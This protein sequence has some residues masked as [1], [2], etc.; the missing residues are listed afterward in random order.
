MERIIL[1]LILC[2]GTMIMTPG[3]EQQAGKLLSEAIYQEEVNGELDE[4]IK[5]YQSIV[6]Q[7]PDDRKVSA[8]ALLHL[9]ICYEKIGMPQAF[10]TYMDIIDKYAEQLDE[11]AL[12]QKR[13]NNLEAYADAIDEKAV[14]HMNKG[15]EL[16]KLW[17]YESAIIEYEEVI[18]LRPNTL[19]AQNAQYNIGQS[20]FKAGR[21]EDALKTFK[22]LIEDYPDSKIVPVT[23]LMVSQ[24]QYTMQNTENPETAKS[25][26]G[27]ATIVDPETDITFRK[28][29]TLTGESDIITYTTDLN[30]SPNGK[31]LLFG[32]MVVPMDGAAPFELI[33]FTST[34]IHVT[35]GTWSPDGNNAA[36]YS[37]DALCVVPV[38]SETGHTTGPVK[39]IYK[40]EL[41]YQRN[42][43]WSPDGKKITYQDSEADLWI[44]GSDGTNLIQITK[45]D[46]REV[47]PAWSPDGKT[48]AY[49]TRGKTLGLYHIGDNKFYELTETGFRWFPDWSPDGKWIV[50]DE[51]GK[52]H[53]YNPDNNSEFDFSPPEETG[54]F[55]SWSRDGG[56]MLFFQTSYFSNSGLKIASPDGGPS[57]EPVPLLTNWWTAGWS[58]DSKYIAVQGEDDNGDIAI[59]IVPLSG[60]KSELI[61][62]D[63]LPDGRPFPFNISSN[64]E[65]VLYSIKLDNGKED[66]Y[67]VPISAE[68]AR[69]TGPAVKIFNKYQGEGPSTLS[70]DGEKLA[71]IYEGNIWM[72]FTNGNDPIQVTDFHEE[73]GYVEWTTDGEALLFSN[74]SGWRLLSN[75]GP[76]GKIIKLLDEGKEIEG[77]HW[78]VDISP[79]KSRFAFSNDE[80]IKI[81]SLDE[82][83]SGQILGLNEL[84]LIEFGELKW[85]P[86]GENLA[87]IGTKERTADPISTFHE[88]RCQIYNISMN[89]GPPIRVAP[90]DDDWKDGLSWSPDGKWIAYSPQKPVKVRP[91][92]SIWVTDFKEILDKLQD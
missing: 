18:E 55:F 12:A 50:G 72:A 31:Y 56:K 36:F 2:F 58:N 70:P 10:D 20:Y 62:L 71:L 84:G 13:I 53:F 32:N 69:T 23:E 57:F 91:A 83:K 79:D 29:K 47:G 39:K 63:D 61:N 6:Q 33:D 28:I 78:N 25:N 68:E 19:L 89:G 65:Q 90:D 11:V 38:S 35:R 77:Y 1:I 60:G 48:I 76:D 24:V 67:V 21:Y 87:F 27:E 80:Q 52:L 22:F 16:F 86:D 43:G 92:S 81:I 9:G 17:E 45:S 88:R 5:T 42:P 41:K 64:L 30:L 46:I 37:G 75:P 44:I 73:V 49:G 54:G 85:S 51:F 15:N 66:L 82:S 8:E 14:G 7:Y 74:S 59:S 3:Q 4:A 26:S 34:G 40:E